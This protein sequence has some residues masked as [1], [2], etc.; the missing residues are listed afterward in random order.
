MKKKI[1]TLVMAV[2]AMLAATFTSCDSDANILQ[3]DETV[4]VYAG[5]VEI[6]W[7]AIEDNFEFEG[8][9]YQRGDLIGVFNYEM[10][11]GD[12]CFVGMNINNKGMSNLVVVV[13]GDEEYGITSQYFLSIDGIPVSE[14]GNRVASVGVR[15]ISFGTNKFNANTLFQPYYGADFDYIDENNVTQQDHVSGEVAFISGNY[16][17][18]LQSTMFDDNANGL[19]GIGISLLFSGW[20]SSGKDSNDLMKRRNKR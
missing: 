12:T 19:K 18:A 16:Q 17:L 4:G 10:A 5:D 6:D 1:Y 20:L 15:E 13:P 8:N 2:S 11:K 14:L 7:Y 9:I 3:A